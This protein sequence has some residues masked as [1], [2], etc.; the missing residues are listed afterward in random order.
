MKHEDLTWELGTKIREVKKGTLRTK[1]LCTRELGTKIREV[2]KG[3]LRTKWLCTNKIFSR[4]S[5]EDYFLAAQVYTIKSFRENL[6]MVCGDAAWKR[7][8]STLHPI[9]AAFPA[10]AMLKVIGLGS[11]SLLGAVALFL[12][13][14]GIQKPNKGI[15]WP[16]I[17]GRR[18]IYIYML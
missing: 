10:T 16:K 11:A 5:L 3:T 13:E 1:R 4:N 2:K 18:H 9:K 12:H 14:T 15:L 17:P 6:K 7:S 8:T